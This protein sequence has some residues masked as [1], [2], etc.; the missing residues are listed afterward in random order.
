[1]E[2]LKKIQLFWKFLLSRVSILQ[3][4]D[5]LSFPFFLTHIVPNV[6]ENVID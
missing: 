3:N 2:A 1:M 5:W 6:N 4:I